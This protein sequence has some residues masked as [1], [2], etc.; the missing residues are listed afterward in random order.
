M[1]VIWLFRYT[2][3]K[4]VQKTY[5]EMN[6]VFGFTYVLYIKVLGWFSNKFLLVI[7]G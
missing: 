6:T 7:S 3:N 5:I 1:N 4:T 2:Y